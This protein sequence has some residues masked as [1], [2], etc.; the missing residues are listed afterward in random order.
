MK[1]L[2]LLYNGSRYSLTKFYLVIFHFLQTH[3][4][5]LIIYLLKITLKTTSTTPNHFTISKSFMEILSSPPGDCRR[6]LL[7]AA[8][9]N[10]IDVLLHKITSHFQTQTFRRSF[11]SV[12]GLHS[13]LDRWPSPSFLRCWSLTKFGGF[14]LLT[15][16][17]RIFT[18]KDRYLTNI[19]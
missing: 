19:T 11:I 12:A 6:L 8:S 14:G 7:P 9:H 15:A 17:R 18:K 10:Y 2:I 13:H 16:V 1:A 4:L 5:I 3:L